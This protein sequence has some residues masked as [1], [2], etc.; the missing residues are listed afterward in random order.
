M[1]Q[2][3][4]KLKSRAKKNLGG[5]GGANLDAPQINLSRYYI[6]TSG[7]GYIENAKH[8]TCMHLHL[9]YLGDDLHSL[10]H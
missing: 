4:D 5:G 6:Y 3:L 7:L 9:T 10:C 8:I 2:N 1:S